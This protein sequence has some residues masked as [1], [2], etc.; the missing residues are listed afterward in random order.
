MVMTRAEYILGLAED[1]D[2][3]HKIR[4]AK[5]LKDYRTK[6]EY[7]QRDMDRS[8]VKG[9][10]AVAGGLYAGHLTSKAVKGIHR[11]IQHSGGAKE[12]ARN[13]V[14]NIKGKATGES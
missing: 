3:D 8:A 11:Q 14:R 2:A 12:V 4:K 5:E 13:V 1:L 6:K 7:S 9:G 10:A